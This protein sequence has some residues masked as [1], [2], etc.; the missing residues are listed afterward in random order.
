MA[1][2]L[3][4]VTDWVIW[5]VILV[6]LCAHVVLA[7]FASI[8]R[9]EGSGVGTVLLWVAYQVAESSGWRTR[10]PTGPRRSSSAT[11]TTAQTGFSPG[12]PTKTKNPGLKVRKINCGV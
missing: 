4:L 1:G 3:T 8:R 5:G 7:L 10:W 9:R 11:C 2:F 6:S 12:F